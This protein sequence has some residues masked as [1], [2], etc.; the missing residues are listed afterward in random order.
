MGENLGT[1]QNFIA[2]LLW[3]TANL[4]LY[5]DYSIARSLWIQDEVRKNDKVHNN[6]IKH[7]MKIILLLEKSK[8]IKTLIFKDF[9]QFIPIRRCP[10]SIL[11]KAVFK[12][13]EN[14]FWFVFKL[15]NNIFSE[16]KKIVLKVLTRKK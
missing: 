16:F 9:K 8:L 6:Y 15:R 3:C 1:N 2:H 14:S 10:T 11:I 7:F 13:T 12:S 4:T 5:D